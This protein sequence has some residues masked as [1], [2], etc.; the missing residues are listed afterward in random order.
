MGVRFSQLANLEREIMRNL[1]ILRGAPASGKSTWIKENNLEPYTLSADN[2]RCLYQSPITKETG[3][4]EISQNNDTAVWELLFELLERRMD[5]GELILIDAT[6]YKSSLISRYKELVHK[7]R[8]RVNVVDFSNVPEE[9]CLRRN[10]ERN[11]YKKVPEEAIS[12]MYACLHDDSEVKK[13][14]KVLSP[15]EAAKLINSPLEPVKCNS[16]K[17]VIFGDIHGCYDPL[18]E[19]FDKN[20]FNDNYCY[21]FCGDYLDRGPQNKEVLEFLL[22]IYK[23]PNVFL[24]EGNHEG[25]LRM[26]ASKDYKDSGKVEATYQDFFVQKVVNQLQAKKAGLTKKLNKSKME[27]EELS[28][29][30]RESWEENPDNKEVF[31]KF[32]KINVPKRQE[33]LREESSKLSRNIESLSLYIELLNYEKENSENIIKKALNWYACE[34]LEEISLDARNIIMRKLN[35]K[36]GNPENPI[37]SFEF[38]KNTIPQIKDLDKSELRQLCD[39]FIQMSYFTYNSHK[40][41]VTHGGLPSLPDMKTPTVEMI[42]GVGKY[43][44]HEKIDKQ[45]IINTCGSVCTVHGHRNVMKV[46]TEVSRGEIYNLEGRIEFGGSLRVLELTKFKDN[47]M[48]NTL[49]IKNNNFIPEEKPVK[50]EKSDLE[51]LKEM[52]DSKWVQVKNLKDNVISLNFTRDAFEKGKWDTITCHARGLFVDK[53]TGDVVA[54]SFGKFLNYHQ[55]ET[56]EPQYMKEHIQWP[57]IGYRKENGF[58]GIVSKDKNGVHFFSKS[59]DEGPYVNWFIG[60]LCDNYGIDYVGHA[61][62]SNIYNESIVEKDLPAKLS[63]LEALELMKHQLRCKLAPFLMEGYSYVFECIDTEN[64]PHIIKYEHNKVIL[65]EVFKNQLKEEHLP[66]DEL[67][68]VASELQV[69]HKNV[70]FKFNT[71]EEFEEWKDKFRQGATQWDCKHEGYVFEDQNNYRVKFKSSYYSFWKQMRGLKDTLA[72]GR[73]NKK[74]YKTKE[75]IQVV[76][77]LEGHTKEELQKMSIIDIEDEFYERNN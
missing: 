3:E 55:H 13:S 69:Y 75:E 20:P 30:L 15:E 70:E 48:Y 37:K 64:D 11:E 32:E 23:K 43:E 6:H 50:E 19:Y 24:L 9:E 53:S 7:Y 60:V 61:K 10:S 57:L 42:K 21:I 54:R 59:T 1:F 77:L 12:K 56:S 36:E 66:Y 22:S 44:D 72:A 34:F 8:Y 5:K 68:E 73:Q 25:R 65:L 63:Q 17:V 62:Y 14:Y 2:I 40:F 45:F 31:Y 28:K 4:R 29:A 35:L 18:K 76:K 33:E 46:D 26:Y 47:V 39:R 74:V 49:D 41:L 67:L 27:I 38:L 52:C 58:L 16:E 51:L 71:W